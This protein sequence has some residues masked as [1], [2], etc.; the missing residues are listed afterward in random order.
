MDTDTF[1]D[2]TLAS[3]SIT[4]HHALNAQNQNETSGK[5]TFVVLKPKR[6]R[7]QISRNQTICVFCFSLLVLI[8]AVVITYIITKNTYSQSPSQYASCA[9]LS[10]RP[11]PFANNTSS[12]EFPPLINSNS[13]LYPWSKIRLPRSAIPTLYEIRIKINLNTFVYEGAVNIT[14]YMNTSTK[15]I[16]FHRNKIA[17][18]NSLI[19][20]GSRYAP[21]KR[22]VNQ[23][24]VKEKNFHVVE[25]DSDLV[26]GHTYVLSVGHYTGKLGTDLKGLYLSSYKTHDGETR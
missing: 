15:Y 23:F 17:I 5:D 26:A 8:V 2:V 16:L 13:T 11:A 24:E 20:V 4:E 21:N 25:V 18:D 6:K 9:P 10:D 1:P 19:T 22:I 12:T 14:L 3:N 7:Y